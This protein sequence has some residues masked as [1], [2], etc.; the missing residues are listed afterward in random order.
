MIRTEWPKYESSRVTYMIYGIKYLSLFN[1]YSNLSIFAFKTYIQW[2]SS[3]CIWSSF[4]SERCLSSRSPAGVSIIIINGGCHFSHSKNSF[5][6]LP[7]SQ[8][9]SQTLNFPNMSSMSGMS[10]TI[11]LWDFDKPRSKYIFEKYFLLC[12]A[13]CQTV[14]KRMEILVNIDTNEN[15]KCNS[16]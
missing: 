3:Q 1:I 7:G 9:F 16:N 2:D 15:K 10:T 4:S 13:G 5:N 8:F 6:F 12:L 11:S 14:L